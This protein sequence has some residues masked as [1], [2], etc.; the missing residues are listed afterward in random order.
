MKK[1]NKRELK[2]RDAIFALH[3][4]KF[5]SVTEKLVEIIRLENGDI[6]D[7]SDDDSYDRNINGEKTEIKGSKVWFSTPLNLDEGNIA[8]TIL[9]SHNNNRHI[10]FNESSKIKW[11]SNI[12]QIKSKLFKTLW[13]VLFFEDCVSIFKITPSQINEDEKVRY[14]D[15]QHRGN[16]GEGQFH[17]NNSN[18]KHHLE[19]YLVETISYEDV[20]NKFNKK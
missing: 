14:S 19:N 9:L 20:Y 15:K 6:V 18:V 5:G 4:R 16:K 7:K 12:Q 13:Y 17:V 3:T 10:S 11:V 2:L 1:M 8:E